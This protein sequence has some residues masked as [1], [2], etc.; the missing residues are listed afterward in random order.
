M[1]KLWLLVS[2]IFL[3]SIGMAQTVHSLYA[4]SAVAP[5]AGCASAPVYKG[6]ALGHADSA[7]VAGP[8]A[9]TLSPP[10]SA[11]NKKGALCVIV[12]TYRGSVT[13]SLSA[14]G[15]QSWNSLTQQVYGTTATRRI[16]W[17]IF[18]GTWS[19]QPALTNT[20]GT[21][22][23][24]SEMFTWYPCDTTHDWH[25]DVAQ[26]TSDSAAPANP[27]NMIV[28]SITTVHDKAVVFALW[29][30]TDDNSFSLSTAGWTAIGP[31]S[32]FQNING[33]DQCL[34]AAYKIQEA[35][36]ATGTAIVQQTNRGGDPFQRA[37]VAFYDTIVPPV[38]CIEEGS[39]AAAPD[40]YTS[41]GAVDTV[42]S[43]SFKSP[44]SFTL[45]Q[46]SIG[47]LRVASDVGATIQCRIYDS[48]HTNILAVAT[49]TVTVNDISNSAWEYKAFQFSGL[50][51][52]ANTWYGAALKYTGA[53]NPALRYEAKAGTGQGWKWA[54]DAWGVDWSDVDGTIKIYSGTCP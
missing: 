13:L 4:A 38:T 28:P 25:V 21:A 11:N 16:F 36:G 32:G 8:T 24:S 33:S 41:F 3:V 52:T 23:L 30:S 7:D 26:V 20:T 2:L 40:D 29:N 44:K 19:A 42:V 45:M 43:F 17:C 50:A 37:V 14:T 9:Q 6:Y 27:Y 46:L 39:F 47:L 48:T 5:P 18:N 53:E 31:P 51:L 12:G 49:G 35:H 54:G 1:K 34:L 10:D 22:A 15:G